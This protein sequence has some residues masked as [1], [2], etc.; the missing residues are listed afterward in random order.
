MALQGPSGTQSL[1][2]S[3]IDLVSIE[4]ELLAQLKVHC[5]TQILLEGL[6]TNSLDLFCFRAALDLMP[7]GTIKRSVRARTWLVE[8]QKHVLAE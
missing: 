8:D 2:E 3:R 4:H 7:C 5:S 1:S 6:Q